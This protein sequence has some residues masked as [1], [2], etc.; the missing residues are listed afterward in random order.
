[1]E[2]IT[3]SRR[4]IKSFH[5]KHSNT[6]VYEYCTNDNGTTYTEHSC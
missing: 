3:S 5:P 6:V 1:M 2:A 4:G